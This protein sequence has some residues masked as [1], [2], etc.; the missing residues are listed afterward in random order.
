[1]AGN[2]SVS[3]SVALPDLLS[4]FTG[5]LSQIKNDGVA[6]N[7]NA[8]ADLYM[9]NY[10]INTAKTINGVTG[11]FNNLFV[12]NLASNDVTVKALTAYNRSGYNTA[13]TASNGIDPAKG[14]VLNDS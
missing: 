14:Y 5:K 10:D 1:M 12:Q 2:L 9:N 7:P 13:Y 11:N 6:F 4:N 8:T 3:G